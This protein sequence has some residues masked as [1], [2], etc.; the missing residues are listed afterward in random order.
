MEA[1]QAPS[2]LDAL[3]LVDDWP[4][5]TA[6]V[7]V[8]RR[9]GDPTG[10]G[11]ARVAVVDSRGP[12]RHVFALASVTKPLV[13]YAVLVAVEEGALGLDDAA[14]PAGS[15]VRHLL[16][17]TSGLGFTT[18]RPMTVPGRRRV[19]SNSGF[20]VLAEALEA[21]TGLTMARYLAEAVTTPLG[22]GATELRG[23]AGAGATSTLADMRLFAAE[24]LVPTLLHPSTLQ[25]ATSVAFPGLS[26]VLPGYGVADPNDWGLGFE[27]RDRK[28]KHWTGRASD[29]ATF[30]HFGR[31]GTF[32]WVDPAADAACVCLTDR[33]F[34]DWSIAAWPVLTDAIL[35]ELKRAK[36]G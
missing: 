3:R 24:L 35:A 6:A 14:G 16:A 21:A 33:D 13:A 25:L 30:G 11:P 4:V 26:G 17:H 34:G 12:D 29:P 10:R 27:L 9:E 31:S 22:M 8:L 2:E 5:D 23:S 1:V 7:A 20:E 32:L 19:Y 36:T 15:T 18:R 28:A